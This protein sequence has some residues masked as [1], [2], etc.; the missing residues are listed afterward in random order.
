MIRRTQPNLHNERTDG[1]P[2]KG[3]AS[4]EPVIRERASGS[5][6]S[7]TVEKDIEGIHPTRHSTRERKGS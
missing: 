2:A 6:L 4:E 7:M 1:P 3:G 5:I